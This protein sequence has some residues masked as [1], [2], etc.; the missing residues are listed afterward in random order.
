[1]FSLSLFYQLLQL[2]KRESSNYLKLFKLNNFTGL[3]LFL[4]IFTIDL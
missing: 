3:L 1:M 4:G 2:K